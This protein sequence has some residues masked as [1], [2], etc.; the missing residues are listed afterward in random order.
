MMT[1]QED[2]YRGFLGN[3][4]VRSDRMVQNPTKNCENGFKR[5]ESGGYLYTNDDLS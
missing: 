4:I 3:N 1:F 2:R 5:K